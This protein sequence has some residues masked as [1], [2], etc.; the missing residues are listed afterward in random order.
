MTVASQS[1]KKQKCAKNQIVD[2]DSED[3]S[4]QPTKSQLD[5]NRRLRNR[6]AALVLDI[7]DVDDVQ[8]W[9]EHESRRG[10]QRTDT[11]I[12]LKSTRLAKDIS[13]EDTQFDEYLSQFPHSRPAQKTA[14]QPRIL[15]RKTVQQ[16]PLLKSAR[17]GDKGINDFVEYG[18]G[19]ENI[20]KYG[21]VSDGEQLVDESPV[22][23]PKSRR[24]K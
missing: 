22:T 23:D 2:D 20:M 18:N 24:G 8:E 16:P 21:A 5:M 6:N 4:R 3:S 15:I 13:Q 12:H 14:G 9:P 7:S 19:D 1:K 17:R 11:D 10:N